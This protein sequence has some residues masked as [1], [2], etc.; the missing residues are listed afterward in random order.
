MNEEDDMATF[1]KLLEI[2]KVLRFY[3]IL[4]KITFRKLFSSEKTRIGSKN[5][6]FH[7]S[8]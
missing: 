6:G 1:L 4:K 8:G 2:K 3:Q 5:S 7:V